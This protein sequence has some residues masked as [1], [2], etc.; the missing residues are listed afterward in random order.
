MTITIET[1]DTKTEYAIVDLGSRYEVLHFGI[2]VAYAKTHEEAQVLLARLA[3]L[4]NEYYEY[5]IET[6][7]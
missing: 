4:V 2:H 1:V 7:A 3:A 5:Y 6:K